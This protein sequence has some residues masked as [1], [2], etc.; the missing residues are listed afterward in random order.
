MQ[1]FI[2]KFGERIRGVLSG[3]D[4]LI[5]RGTLRRLNYGRWDAKLGAQVA[6]GWRNICGRTRFCSKTTAIM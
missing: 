5:F 3:F 1:Q 4:R 6:R 2:R